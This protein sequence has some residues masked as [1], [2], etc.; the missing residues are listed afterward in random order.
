MEVRIDDRG[1][2][3]TPRVSKESVASVVRT[4]DHLIVGN[5]YVRPD[6]RLKDELNEDPDRFLA[7]TDAFVYDAYGERLLFGSSFLLVAYT[8]VILIS[9]VEALSDT[10]EAIWLQ[11]MPKEAQ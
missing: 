5:V 2:Y 11:R 4:T 10:A 9:P 1:K 6:R 8:H 7:I 3:F